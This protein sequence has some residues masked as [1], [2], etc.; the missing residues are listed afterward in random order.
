[1]DVISEEFVFARMGEPLE[2]RLNN[3]D[4][5]RQQ[6]NSLHEA[7]KKFTRDSVKSDECWETFDRLEEEWGKYNIRY[8]EESYR[9]G[10]EDGVQL[11]SEREIRAE[12]SVLDV[13]DM[14]HLVSIYDAVKKLNKLLLGEWEIH[15]RDGGVLE[16][17]DRVCD[18][19]EHGV[20]AEL[21]LRGENEMYERL[22]DILDDAGRAPEER[23]KLLTEFGRA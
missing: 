10:F 19:I 4:S 15:G 17:L 9:L 13:Q 21:R 20:C 8:G 18:V 5:F 7:A 23:A 22:A 12:S 16:E 11:A 14:A 3:S 1:M 6:M 2:T